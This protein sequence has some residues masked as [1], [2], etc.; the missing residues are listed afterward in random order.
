MLLHRNASPRL[1]AIDRNNIRRF[2]CW[3]A[4]SPDL[5][6]AIE[7]VSAVLP[8]RTNQYVVEELID[9]DKVPSDPMYQLTFCHEGMLHPEQYSRMRD[10][11]RSGAPQ[12]AV[13][14]AAD[15]IRF[16]LNPHPAGQLTHNAVHLDGRRLPGM[17]HKYRET[18]LFFPIQG[19]T[20]H[21]YC[22]FCFRWAQFVGI[23]D[24]RMASSEAEDLV[25][26]LR[27]H[28]EVTD[29]LITGGDPMIM[30]AKFLARYIEPLLDSGLESLRNIRIG[31]KSVGYWPQRFVS[32]PDSDDILRLFDKVVASGRQLALMAHYNHPVELSTPV[33]REATMRM[34]S[35][36]VRHINDDPT[37]WASLWRAG[38]QLGVVPYYLFIERDT[39][40]RNYFEVPLVQAWQ[41]FRQAYQQVSGLARTVRGP[42]MSADPARY[43]S[44]V[45]PR[46]PTAVCSFS[47]ICRPATRTVSAARSSPNSTRMPLG[48]TTWNPPSLPTSRCSIRRP[49]RFCP[50]R[51]RYE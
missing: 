46:S 31:T 44:S 23:S 48:S 19:Q 34:Q 4:L 14:S 47:S 5:Q 42:S 21:A 49:S 11:S 20:C 38:T 28:P 29:V 27:A 7:V 26:Y 24:L 40:A 2:S 41:I 22:S 43:G 45:S 6:E 9:W 39:G 30:K 17:Q 25:N 33:A 15:A 13:K 8:F 12:S 35:P 16:R 32:D 18:V 36:L 3:S 50:I 1:Q 51:C 10:L 37:A